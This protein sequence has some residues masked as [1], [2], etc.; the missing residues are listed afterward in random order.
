MASSAAQ[1]RVV[2]GEIV[3]TRSMKSVARGIA[4]RYYLRGLLARL[5]RDREATRARPP[6]VALRS[7]VRLMP[8]GRVPVCQFNTQTV[9]DLSAE[10]FR[11]VWHGTT[12]TE[13]RAWVDACPGCWA[14]CEVMPS[15][16]Y[17]G[18]LVRGL[19]SRG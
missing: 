1:P 8:D 19:A 15:A 17:T 7:H 5:R 6:C 10:S 2:E 3:R 16:I 13:S 14:E 11:A 18:D 4:K 9:G 12:A